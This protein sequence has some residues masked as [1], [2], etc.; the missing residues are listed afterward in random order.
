MSEGRRRSPGNHPALAAVALACALAAGCPDEA[1]EEASACPDRKEAPPPD[2]G[3]WGEGPGGG[4]AGGDK[5]PATSPL[6][7]PFLTGDG[8]RFD[9]PLPGPAPDDLSGRVL[10]RLVHSAAGGAPFATASVD[11]SFFEGGDAVL[12]WVDDRLLS[13]ADSCGRRHRDADAPATDGRVFLEAGNLC[14]VGGPASLEIPPETTATGRRVHQAPALAP[15]GDLVGGGSYAV[16]VTGGADLGAREF[17]APLDLPPDIAV[18][19]P[20]PGDVDLGGALGFQWAPPAPGS[21]WDPEVVVAAEPG[22]PGSPPEGAGLVFISLVGAEGRVVHEVHCAAVDDGTFTVPE[23]LVTGL[24]AGRIRVEVR[25]AAT[26][27]VEAGPGL[28]VALQGEV[29]AVLEGHR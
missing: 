24:P 6:V 4:P 7:P 2:G 3:W 9:V 14:V 10:A 28:A 11:A 18:S 21:T 22:A 26:R 20:S 13:G 5:R 8:P 12:P 25:R 23:P 29:A 19:A 16:S 15:G 27:W 17:A 1:P